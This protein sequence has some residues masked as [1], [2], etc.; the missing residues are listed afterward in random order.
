MITASGNGSLEV[1]FDRPQ[2]V[3]RGYIKITN[4]STDGT[5]NWRICVVKGSTE[6]LLTDDIPATANEVKHIYLT[7]EFIV[8]NLE[9]LKI[10]DTAGIDATG[11]AIFVAL[12]TEGFEKVV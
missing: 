5:R 1:Y 10:Y 12:Q 4:S 9:K 8:S 7:S 6:M 3:I 11:D 2:K